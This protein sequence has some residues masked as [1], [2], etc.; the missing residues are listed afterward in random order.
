M[1]S[2]NIIN[3]VYIIISFV[4]VNNSDLALKIASNT[5][6]DTDSAREQLFLS[7]SLL[8]YTNNKNNKKETN[9]NR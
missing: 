1:L 9:E 8:K 2:Q 7:Q 3:K 5:S 4:E 6:P